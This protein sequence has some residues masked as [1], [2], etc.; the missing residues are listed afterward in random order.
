[1]QEFLSQLLTN[2]FA[3]VIAPVTADKNGNLLN[4]NAD[5]VAQALAQALS[6]VYNTTLI[7]C[8]EKKGLLLDVTDASSVITEIKFG[9]AEKMKKKGIITNG[10]VPKVDNAFRAL[11]SGVHSVVMGHA[12]FIKKMVLQEKG[13]G[14]YFKA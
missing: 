3:P 12:G 8:F 14:T 13:Y 7:Y 1:M 2:G 9:D 5:T 4:I 10:T 6:A 11:Q